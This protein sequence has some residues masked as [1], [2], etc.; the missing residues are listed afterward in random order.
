MLV[1]ILGRFTWL[2]SMVFDALNMI[3]S[4]IGGHIF[5]HSASW[6]I[7]MPF[8]PAIP[9]K[10]VAVGY[11]CCPINNHL[12]RM[13]MG[14]ESSEIQL[15]CTLSMIGSLELGLA[16]IHDMYSWRLHWKKENI[17]SPPKWTT[18]MESKHGGL[19]DEKG[20]VQVFIVVFWGVGLRKWG[21]SNKPYHHHRCRCVCD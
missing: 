14:P 9:V 12:L 21:D 20:H 11:R 13:V 1:T 7:K 2:C 16:A 5:S 8:T 19:E 10:N 17:A 6:M 15:H 4:F 18:N 3:C